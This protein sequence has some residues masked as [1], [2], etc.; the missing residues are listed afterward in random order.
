MRQLVLG[1][2][3]LMTTGCGPKVMKVTM[4]SD[5]NSG[6]TGFAELTDRGAKGITV[7]VETSAPD[8]RTANPDE[9]KQKAHIHRGN[10]GEVGEKV[11]FLNDLTALPGKPDRFGSTTELTTP[12]FAMFGSE[13][14]IIN[15]HDARDSG[16]YTSCGEIPRP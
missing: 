12:T 11:G 4:L 13:E 6:Q 16:I 10:C 5:N 9:E 2:A 8:Y 15:V 14:W 7:M 1:L 3:L